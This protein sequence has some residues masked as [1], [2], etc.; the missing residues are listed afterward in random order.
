MTRPLAALPMYDWPEVRTANDRLWAAIRDHLRGGGVAAPEQLSRGADLDAEWTDAGLVLGQTC[1]LPL[2][3]SLAGRVVVLGAAD[4][5]LPGCPPGWYRS[6]VVIRADDRRGDDPRG[7]AAFRGATLAINGRDSQSGWGSILHHAGPHGGEALFDAVRV[8]GAHLSSI[9][10]VAAGRADLAAIDAVTW[11]FA[12]RHRPAAGRLRVLLETD[13]TPG[14]PYIAAPGTDA[15]A[16][17]VALA[18]GID[19]LRT[20]DR[21][22]LGIVALAPLTAADYALVA[23]RFETALRG[24]RALPDG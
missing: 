12:L 8:T 14:L 3:T 9:E 6:A 24:P 4:M 21:A 23:R 19:S 18:A 7:L 17:R 16:V 11:R 1:G 20:D 22:A 2:V 13:P 10:A 5:G 15:A